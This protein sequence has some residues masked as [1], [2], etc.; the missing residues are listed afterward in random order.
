MNRSIR[1]EIKDRRI[2]NAD[3]MWNSVKNAIMVLKDGVYVWPLPK[4]HKNTRSVQQNNYYWGV[5]CDILSKETG[6]TPEEIHQIL[7]EKFLSYEKN[8][9]RFVKSTTKL[10]TNEFEEYMEECRRFASIELSCYIPLPNEPDNFYYDF[11]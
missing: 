6:Y 4:M 8:E 11:K 9:M 5:V 10:K 1:L 7:G 2:V 3:K